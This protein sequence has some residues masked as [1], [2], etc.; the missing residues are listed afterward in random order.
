[1]FRGTRDIA[2]SIFRLVSRLAIAIAA[3]QGWLSVCGEPASGRYE[4]PACGDPPAASPA[5]SI[6]YSNPKF[7]RPEMA[8]DFV[9]GGVYEVRTAHGHPIEVWKPDA[10]DQYWC[11]G[12]T[13]GGFDVANGPYSVEGPSVPIVLQDEYS[14]IPSYMAT[15][16][17]AVIF[18]DAAGA[19]QHS[20][21]I[22]RVA[23]LTN[24]GVRE[25]DQGETL[26]DSRWGV[27]LQQTCSLRVT[28]KQ[29]A[30]DHGGY[31]FYRKGGP[32]L[33][34]G[35]GRGADEKMPPFE[36]NPPPR[37]TLFHLALGPPTPPGFKIPKPKTPARPAIAHSDKAPKLG[38]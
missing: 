32:L 18:F 15:P 38:R 13:F 7:L 29:Y 5:A 20:G 25:I 10:G 36:E 35:I 27:A 24:H 19:V 2:S 31:A 33:Q 9:P 17:D 11:H 3:F 34:C 21:I 12:F 30:G 6:D 4:G 16:G 14:W 23:L 37:A 8:D 1:M 22:A 28:Q 26:I